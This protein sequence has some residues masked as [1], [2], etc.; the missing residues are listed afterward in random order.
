MPGVQITSPRP[1]FQRPTVKNRRPFFCWKIGRGPFQ[2]I[3]VLR[4]GTGAVAAGPGLFT[5]A[6]A[7]CVA[8]AGPLDY[9]GSMSGCTI[10]LGREEDCQFSI[11]IQA[12]PGPLAPDAIRAEAT[13][14]SKPPP[15]WTGGRDRA[16]R[17]VQGLGNKHPCRA[18]GT[19]VPG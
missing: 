3:K 13:R 10:A 5:P 12:I 11:A 9:W 15:A 16:R 8:F 7:A 2:G 17:G 14:G 6:V 4:C 18:G 19:R 1:E